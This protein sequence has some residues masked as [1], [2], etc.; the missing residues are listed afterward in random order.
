MPDELRE[1]LLSELR[2]A[3]AARLLAGT[4]PRRVAA[5]LVRRLHG[6]ATMA[7]DD[8]PPTPIPPMPPIPPIPPMPP[9]PGEWR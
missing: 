2:G 5:G 6:L 7:G 3:V 4:D 8:V 9:T 1:H